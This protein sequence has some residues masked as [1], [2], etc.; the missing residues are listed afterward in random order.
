MAAF[1]VSDTA[2]LAAINT[3]DPKDDGSVTLP[4]GFVMFVISPGNDSPS[5]SFILKEEVN[6]TSSV[7]NWIVVP[8]SRVGDQVW[9][10]LS[11]ATA[12]NNTPPSFI[13][14][15]TEYIGTEWKS[16]YTDAPNGLRWVEKWVF[17]GVQW[18][19]IPSTITGNV[20]PTFN[21]TGQ[22]S[23]YYDDISNIYIANSDLTG[24]TLLI[25]TNGAT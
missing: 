4:L 1:F 23:M 25:I 22:G 17:D 7:E 19:Y 12:A 20:F 15:G 9:V 3:A 21:P 24:W 2:A 10:N 16:V 11:G 8:S 14:T 6:A 18:S 5:A 13:P